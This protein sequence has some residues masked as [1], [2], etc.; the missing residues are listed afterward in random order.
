M[1]PHRTR[2]AGAL[3]L[4]VALAACGDTDERPA[5]WTYISGSI[6]Q[7]NCATSRCHAKG[8]AAFGVQLDSLEGGYTVLVGSPPSAGAPAGRN[9]VVPGDPSAP[10]RMYLLARQATERMPPD[11]PLPEADIALVERWILEGARF[12]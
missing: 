4:L 5:T 3:G 8:S 6:I 12:E 7:P 10:K 1:H 9:F 11:A 2:V